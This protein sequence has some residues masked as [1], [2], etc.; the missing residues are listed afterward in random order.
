MIRLG[1]SGPRGCRDTQAFPRFR[2]CTPL[3]TLIALGHDP[4]F[5]WFLDRPGDVVHVL[6]EPRGGSAKCRSA[7]LPLPDQRPRSVPSHI[8]YNASCM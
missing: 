7:Y 5:I 6:D 1:C 8:P 3:A 2:A 4:S